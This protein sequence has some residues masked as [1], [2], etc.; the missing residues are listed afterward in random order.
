M[1]SF[2]VVLF[3]L[4]CG[5]LASQKFTSQT[6]YV[7]GQ[8]KTYELHRVQEGDAITIDGN[9]N[10]RSWLHAE[11][12]GDFVQV[13]SATAPAQKTRAKMLWT[14][15]LLYV[16]VECED[17]NITSSMTHRDDPLWK[18]E[19]VEL[20]IAGGSLDDTFES[21]AEIEISP[22]N[23]I[24]DLYVLRAIDATP[25]SLPYNI[26]TLTLNTAVHL[27]G[28]LNDSTDVDKGWTVEFSVPIKELKPITRPAPK[29]GDRWRFNLYRADLLP[30]RELTA[31]NPT[32]LNKFHVPAK[33]G[34]LLFSAKQAGQ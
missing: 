12:T 29:N 2:I 23:V 19:V 4:L 10:E 24:F 15:S 14:D 17:V 11:S 16:G 1:R 34:E 31:W 7:W 26:Y 25:Q 22:R 13:S 27:N 30:R 33:F 18:E 21:Y 9:L 8:Q 5:C 32:G 28:T 6:Q 3:L 20:F